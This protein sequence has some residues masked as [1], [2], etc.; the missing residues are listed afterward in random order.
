MVHNIPTTTSSEPF[1]T[2]LRSDRFFVLG[3]LIA[4]SMLAWGYSI[5][6][7]HELQ[8][9]PAAH[10][11]AARTLP[12]NLGD[13]GLLFLM[14]TVMMT[15]MMVPTAAPMVLTFAKIRRRQAPD[16]GL[17]WPVVGFVLGYVIVWTVFSGVATVVE[18]RLHVAMLLD[19]DGSSANPLFGGLLLLIAGIFQWTPLKQACLRHC[20]SPLAFFISSWRG[21]WR[22]ALTMGLEHG[23]YCVGCCWA[24]MALMFVAGVMNFLWLTI[25]AAFVLLEKI[26]PSGRL[27]TNTAGI[28]LTVWGLYLISHAVGQMLIS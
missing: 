4:G 16:L 22:G 11:G 21:G 25:I 15:A 9:V 23:I 17:V 1:K 12:W 18:W 14:W 27:V 28:L 7:A 3:G 2:V 8:H 19:A 10:I 13:L 26:V 24:L 20:R 6:L 5:R